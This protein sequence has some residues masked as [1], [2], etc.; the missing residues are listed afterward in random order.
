M[1]TSIESLE[2]CADLTREHVVAALES[3]EATRR[4]C[5]RLAAIARPDGGVERLLLVLA[6]IASGYAD[7][8]DADLRLEIVPAGNDTAVHTLVDLGG[9]QRERLFPTLHLGVPFGEVEITVERHLAQL[10][11]LE[12][13]PTSEGLVLSSVDDDGGWEEGDPIAV[14]SASMSD[15]LF[16]VS[17]DESLRTPVPPPAA[18]HE[19][20]GDRAHAAETA[21]EL[22]EAATLP[23]AAVPEGKPTVRL[24]ATKPTEKRTESSQGAPTSGRTTIRAPAATRAVVAKEQAVQSRAQRPDAINPPTPK[25]VVSAELLAELREDAGDASAENRSSAF[26]AARPSDESEEK[27]LDR[28]SAVGERD[29][30]A[31][32]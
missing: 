9:H 21:P 11:P 30:P 13:L 2:R 15:E 5:E 7:W 14:H 29:R 12:L 6:S 16:L 1:G 8:F 3:R 32:R 25:F 10:S 24:R 27:L 4:L 20:D 31:R 26:L 19:R 28:A 18:T 22:T 17:D 23:P